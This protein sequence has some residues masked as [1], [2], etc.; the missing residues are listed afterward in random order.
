MSCHSS[1]LLS[2]KLSL[3]T[4]SQFCVVLNQSTFDPYITQHPKHRGENCP[5]VHS[6]LP[7]L[8]SG[9]I[10]WLFFFKL[11]KNACCPE[12]K[13]HLGQYFPKYEYLK[14]LQSLTTKIRISIT[15]SYKITKNKGNNPKAILQ[16]TQKWLSLYEYLC[17]FIDFDRPV[18]F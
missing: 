17:G 14:H 12:K 5:L 10:D 18:S 4:W 7:E 9:L 3:I 1:Y 15:I 11:P 16:K 6:M 13:L 8:E 2:H